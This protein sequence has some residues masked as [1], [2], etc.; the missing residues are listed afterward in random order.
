MGADNISVLNTIKEDIK[1]SV[2]SSREKPYTELGNILDEL[3][4][5]LTQRID[6]QNTIDVLEDQAG[7]QDPKFKKVRE[8]IRKKESHLHQIEAALEKF[9]DPNDR[10]KNIDTFGLQI[11]EDRYKQALGGLQ[12]IKDV[13]NIKRKRD[14]LEKILAETYDKA[15]KSIEQ[16]ICQETNEKIQTLLPYNNI[17]VEKIDKGLVLE[18]QDSGSVGENL[19]VGYAFLSTLF[20]HSAHELPFVVDSPAGAID[21]KVRPEV[22]KLIPKLSNQ[23]IAFTISSERE[24]FLPALKQACSSDDIEYITLCRKDDS[25]I[26]NGDSAKIVTTVDGVCVYDEEYFN[27]FQLEQEKD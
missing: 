12:E 3:N 6:I 22:G 18:G 15:L 16:Q 4:N 17:R 27:H 5:L 21:L 24:G 26:N 8:E 2:E 23:F 9:E 13:L 7:E 1:N 14:I 11:L 25:S 20:T 19:S 10:K